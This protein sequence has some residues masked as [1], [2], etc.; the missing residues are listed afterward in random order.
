MSARSK[1]LLSSLAVTS[2]MATL[3]VATTATD[4]TAA[5]ARQE[6][7]RNGDFDLGGVGWYARGSNT[8]VA[9]INRGRS[10]SK[11]A[12]LTNRRPG[13][14]SGEPEH[15]ATFLLNSWRTL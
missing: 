7:M 15:G 4:A 9:I 2:M 12:R 14:E 13:P 5:P 6:T 11:A 1:R 3:A 8:K 10:G